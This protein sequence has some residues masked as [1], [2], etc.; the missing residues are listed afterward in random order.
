MPVITM[1]IQ[2]TKTVDHHYKFGDSRQSFLVSSNKHHS[3]K[4]D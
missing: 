3:Q 1:I 4:R 2:K